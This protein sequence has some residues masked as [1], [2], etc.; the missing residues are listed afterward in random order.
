MVSTDMSALPAIAASSIATRSMKSAV[1]RL[2]GGFAD[3]TKTTRSQPSAKALSAI[4]MCAA[5]GGS[6]APPSNAVPCKGLIALLYNISSRQS[7]IRTKK[8]RQCRRYAPQKPCPPRPTRRRTHR[9]R[10]QMPASNVS[11]TSIASPIS[12]SRR[13][14]SLNRHTLGC[15]GSVTATIAMSAR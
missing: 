9:Q 14:H 8:R 10:P 1:Q 13:Q 12:F 3:G 11:Y 7:M 4:W 2:C 5:C 6:N 15:L